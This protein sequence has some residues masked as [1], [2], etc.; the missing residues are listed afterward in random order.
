MNEKESTLVDEVFTSLF[1]LRA[2]MRHNEE[3]IKETAKK[4]DVAPMDLLVLVVLNANLDM[5]HARDLAKELRCSKG[6]ISESVYR[7]ETG[8]YLE[9]HQVESDRRKSK[10]LLTEKAID[11]VQK[12]SV[13]FKELENLVFQ[14]FTEEDV[15][16]FKRLA[17]KLNRNIGSEN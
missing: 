7:L 13:S 10:L 17:A 1:S 15:E 4:L 14:D 12:A 6:R 11:T 3:Y 2:V 8:G 9:K 5:Y 16:E